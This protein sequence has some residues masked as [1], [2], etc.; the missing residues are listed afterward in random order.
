MKTGI[1]I[2]ISA[3][4]GAGKTTLIKLLMKKVIGL[5]YSVSATTRPSSKKE[6]NGRDYFF[7][8]AKEFLQRKKANEFIETALVHGHHYGTLKKQLDQKLKTGKAVVLD[9]DVK[10]AINVRKHCPQSLLIFI[11]P[12]SIKILEERIKNRHRDT[13]KE[14]Q[15]RL[16][17]ARKE[18]RY[19]KFYDYVIVNDKLDRAFNELK[20]IMRGVRRTLVRLPNPE[21]LNKNM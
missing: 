2:V 4:S 18:M 20:K 6:K 14:I 9:V 21:A 15:R 7:I 5:S 11:A 1:P 17:N 13:E 3:P 10:G 12:P 8:S 19:K 16:K